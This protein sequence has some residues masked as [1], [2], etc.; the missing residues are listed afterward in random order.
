MAARKTEKTDKPK[1][2]LPKLKP[3]MFF[4]KGNVQIQK[5]NRKPLTI[6]RTG[7]KG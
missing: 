6:R 2:A 5:T 4:G 3:Q 1:L 7:H